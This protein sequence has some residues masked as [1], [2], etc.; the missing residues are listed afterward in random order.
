M[1]ALPAAPKSHTEVQRRRCAATVC[2]EHHPWAGLYGALPMQRRCRTSPVA[3][4]TAKAVAKSIG[5][6][7]P[8]VVAVGQPIGGWR[9]AAVLV[10]VL[11]GVFAV[12][13]TTEPAGTLV[14]MMVM[15]RP[16]GGLRHAMMTSPT[17]VPMG[18]VAAKASMAPEAALDGAEVPLATCF[19][20]CTWAA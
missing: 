13:P 8:E 18:A 16:D 4:T 3:W 6:A 7:T 9:C 17:I 5:A 14:M 10:V 2:M 12:M 20:C 11:V 15:D 19:G 1:E